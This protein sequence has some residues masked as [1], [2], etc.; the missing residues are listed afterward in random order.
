MAVINGVMLKGRH[1]VVPESLKTQ[2]LEQ[3]HVNYKGIEKIKLMACK[4]IYW[5]NINDDNEKHIKHCPTCL[6]FQQ[7]QPKEK[8][9]HHKIQAKPW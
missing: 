7:T 6:D 4:S 5:A 2:A 3:L 1:V 9:I 8:I